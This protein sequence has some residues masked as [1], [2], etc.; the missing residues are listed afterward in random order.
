MSTESVQGSSNSAQ[1]SGMDTG[2]ETMPQKS[3]RQDSDGE[4]K[5][6]ADAEEHEKSPPRS[7]GS[8]SSGS[9]PADGRSSKNSPERKSQSGSRPESLERSSSGSRPK[10]TASDEKIEV[11]TKKKLK[12]TEL[13]P[14]G[15]EVTFTVTISIAVPTGFQQEPLHPKTNYDA[16]L[17][18]RLEVD[19]EDQPDINDLVKRKKRVFEAPRAQ[20]YYHLEY[21]LVPGPD[22]VMKTD[23][24]TYG[25]GA[26]IYMERHDPF[27]KKTWH[28]GDVTWIAWTQKH[29][30][31]ITKDLLL[32]L[33]THTLE[34]RLW[35]T[36]DKIGMRAKFDRPK[37]FKLPSLKQGEEL[38]DLGGVKTTVL[39]QSQ[40]FTDLQPKKACEIRPLP[41]EITFQKQEPPGHKKREATPGAEKSISGASVDK[42]GAGATTSPTPHTLVGVPKRSDDFDGRSSFSRLGRLADQEDA[43]TGH[44]SRASKLSSRKSRT[45]S[46]ASKSRVDLASSPARPGAKSAGSSGSSK[47]IQASHQSSNAPRRRNRK[48]EQ[49]AQT[50]AEHIKKHGICMIPIRMAVLFS[51][52][53]SVTNR[54]ETPIPGV[55]DVFVTLQLNK[56]L[57]NDKQKQELNPMI[58]KI[59]SATNMPSTPLSHQQ[60]KDRC[61]PTFCRYSFFNLPSHVTLKRSHTPNVYWDDINVIL[62]GTFEQ[63]EFRQ[64]LN[65]PPLEIEVHDRD[66]KLEEVKLKPTLFGDDLEDEKISNVGTVASRRTLH[67]PFKDKSKIWDPYGVAKVDLSD[68]LLGHRYLYIK[69]PVHSCPPPDLLGL[70]D[71]RMG[72]KMVGLAGA[73]DGPVDSPMPGGHYIQTNTML[74]VKV[75]LAQ[76]LVTPQE[77]ANKGHIETTNECPF[78][79]IV[80]RFGYK[81]TVMLNELQNLVTRINARALELDDMPQHVID[82]ALST[83]KLSGIQQQSR[84][85]DIVTGFQV[86]DG[87]MHLFVLEG[88]RE[89]AVKEV[90]EALPQPENSDVTVL[91]HSNLCFSE[92]LYGPLDVDLCRVKLHEPLA[93]IVSQPLLYV[94]D[95]VPKPCFEA[96]TKLFEMSKIRNI[97][98]AARSVLFPSADMVVSMSK[99]FGVPFTT[100]DFEDLLVKEERSYRAEVTTATH[101]QSFLRE[102]SHFWEPIDNQNFSY[103]ER[104]VDREKQASSKDFLK[105]HKR[106]LKKASQMNRKERELT[107][108]ATVKMDVAVAHNYSSQSLNSTEM[109]KEKL[110]Q[111]LAKDPDTRYTYC[112]EYL[113]SMTVVPVNVEALKKQEKAESE[114]QWKTEDGF[115]YPGVK[116]TLEANQHPKKPHTA[117]IDELEE[118]WREN[119]LHVG[120]LQPP[121][122]RD[123]F[124][125]ELRDRD[126][127]L[128]QK[129]VVNFGVPEPNTIHLAGE[130]LRQEKLAALRRDKE[131][132]KSK[133]IVEDTR[134]Y[135][136]RCLTETELSAQGR[137]AS[138]QL[139]RLQG[140]LKD[141]PQKLSLRRPG[142]H[143]RN[144]PPLNVV[145]NPSVDTDVRATG[146]VPEPAVEG[147]GEER[148]SGFKPGPFPDSSWVVEHNK[149]PAV[150]YEHDKFD[151]IKGRDFNVYHKSRQRIWRQP[152]LPLTDEERDNHLFRIPDD[153]KRFR[154]LPTLSL[155]DRA[156]TQPQI[157]T[158]TALPSRTDPEHSRLTVPSSYNDPTLR[159]TSEP[160]GLLSNQQTAVSPAM[161]TQ[162]TLEVA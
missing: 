55:E 28:E 150:D 26:K 87:E 82:A 54:L 104:L 43:P 9:R 36:K 109:A 58:I 33:H 91:Y 107:K 154:I 126:L 24:V 130:K 132:W 8:R 32:K 13:D 46:Q 23:V 133:V 147:E 119:M 49:A 156:L 101:E 6:K 138:N 96:L 160:T 122:E 1:T 157:S 79:R 139:S 20:N 114:A 94:R 84:T 144:I 80:F 136:H 67:N 72:G 120:L 15:H 146:V 4:T 140:L 74:K 44:E 95:M 65:G 61:M 56:P 29:K 64:Y 7:P 37:L 60:L 76:P 47:A 45:T 106:E 115:V 77:V 108:P 99:E 73:V 155:G 18:R 118:Q 68:L 149:I 2:E 41:K 19:D 62:A 116:T 3:P 59:H 128:Y 34:L 125:W 124:T 142:M 51:G 141:H 86:L 112:Q 63:S 92:R 78:S 11:K 88:L 48:A 25:P 111:M 121:L 123:R 97:R 153:P 134:Q 145:L 152:I 42:S 70:G 129:P 158:L 98:D 53:E 35:D 137:K 151:R 161:N 38:E 103:M 90:W 39:K 102:S 89:G 83:Y 85:L 117:R 5:I 12:P 100:E 66:R 110:R 159:M 52:L 131:E 21:Y 93:Q 10:S 71:S 50:A 27:I 113:H 135:F 14:D 30:L 16:L 69:V 22:E 127:E 81:N 57:L 75:E 40:S 162:R 148:N 31:Y 143:L 105:E 17:Y